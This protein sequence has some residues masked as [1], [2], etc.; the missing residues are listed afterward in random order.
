MDLC[1]LDSVSIRHWLGVELSLHSI[2]GIQGTTVTYTWELA[3]ATQ[4]LQHSR[5]HA[6]AVVG[7]GKATDKQAH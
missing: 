2:V 6:V 5:I 3:T 4:P 1:S 7:P